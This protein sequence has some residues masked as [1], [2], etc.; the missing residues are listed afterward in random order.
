L[1]GLLRLFMGETLDLG[2]VGELLPERRRVVSSSRRNSVTPP[3]S[4]KV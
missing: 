1:E 2:R 3:T 4:R